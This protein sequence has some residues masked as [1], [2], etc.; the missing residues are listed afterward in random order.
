MLL[1]VRDVARPV[2]GAG[3]SRAMFGTSAS[4][5]MRFAGSSPTRLVVADGVVNPGD[6]LSISGE[7]HAVHRG[8]A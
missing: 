2:A 5:Q 1:W 3:V 8:G 7:K 4:S 6:G